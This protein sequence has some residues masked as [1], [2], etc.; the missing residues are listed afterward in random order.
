M[1]MTPTRHRNRNPRGEGERLRDEIIDAAVAL[2]G[3]HGQEGLSLRAIARKAGVTA[4][5]IYAHF[6]DLDSVRRAVMSSAFADFAEYLRRHGSGHRNP[7]GRLRALC[8]AY[9]EYGIAQPQRYAVMFGP[10]AKPPSQGAAT[11]IVDTPGGEAFTLLLNAIRGCVD[12]GAS[13]STQP[14]DDAIAVW[15]ALHGYVGL[16]TAIRDIPWPA[17]DTLLDTIVDRLAQLS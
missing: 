5:A 17:G 7:A 11:S 12:A 15:V 1:C 3:E 16:H 14:Y 10:L 9:T 8:R 4:P 2:I 13:H 6:E